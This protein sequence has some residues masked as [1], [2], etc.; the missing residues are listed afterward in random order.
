MTRRSPRVVRA[1]LWMRV[2]SGRGSLLRA[3]RAFLQGQ[4]PGVQHIVV[5]GIRR[6]PLLVARALRLQRLVAVL[7]RRGRGAEPR[8]ERHR[9]H[10]QGHA[11]ARGGRRGHPAG[12]RAECDV[13]NRK[14]HVAAMASMGNKSVSV[15]L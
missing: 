11:P 15:I 7:R 12:A 1:S 4:A 6:V 13:S 14:V 10:V 2:R 3:L 5:R 8:A 9:V